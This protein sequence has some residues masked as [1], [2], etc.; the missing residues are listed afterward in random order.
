M[1]L[2]VSILSQAVSVHTLDCDKW[3][4]SLDQMKP[5]LLPVVE[6]VCYVMDWL[7]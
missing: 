1:C 3:S 4:R 6:S 5:Q 2:R 7:I